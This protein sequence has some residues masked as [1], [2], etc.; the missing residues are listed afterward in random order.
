[1]HNA[2][3]DTQKSQFTSLHKLYLSQDSAVRWEQWLGS[4][5]ISF[6]EGSKHYFFFPSVYTGPGAQPASNPND[7]DWSLPKSKV[8]KKWNWLLSSI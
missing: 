6:L 5:L 4:G 1:M 8:A 7:S 2:L 3:H